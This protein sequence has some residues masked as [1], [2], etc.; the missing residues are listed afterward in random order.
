[1][2]RVNARAQSSPPV[3]I[4]KSQEESWSEVMVLMLFWWMRFR[5]TDC[6]GLGSTSAVRVI[7]DNWLFWPC[8]DAVRSCRVNKISQNT[9]W[10][11][12][13]AVQS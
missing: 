1:M 13:L 2:T 10:P 11:S 3:A 12:V 7:S 9:I 5:E 8:S 4:R 6:R